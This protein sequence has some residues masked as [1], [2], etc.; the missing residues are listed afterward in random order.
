MTQPD[1]QPGS[2]ATPVP[3]HF[4][5][6]IEAID[7]DELDKENLGWTKTYVAGLR[8]RLATEQAAA[9]P[10]FVMISYLKKEIATY[11][12]LLDRTGG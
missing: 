6:E 10:D 3:A 9:S 5:R 1:P 8:D 11:Q 7:V 4:E 2:P 12:E